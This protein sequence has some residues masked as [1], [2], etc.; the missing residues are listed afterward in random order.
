M[1]G[2]IY[3]DPSLLVSTLIQDANTERALALVASAKRVVAI[4]ELVDVEI[5]NALELAAFR[6]P[7]AVSTVERAVERYGR[8]IQGGLW[9]MIEVDY[10]RCLQRARGLSIAY[11]RRSGCRSLDILHVAGAMELGIRKFWSLDAKQSGLAREVGMEV[12]P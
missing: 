10:Q 12:S 8:M 2:L 1:K 4:T 5:R 11:T 6:S 9:R 3:A 7:R